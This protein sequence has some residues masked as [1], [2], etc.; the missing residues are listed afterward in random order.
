MNVDAQ[1]M[2]ERQGACLLAHSE[3]CW[4]W[5]FRNG[6]GDGTMT[7]YQVFPGVMLSFN[8]FHME[9]YDCSFVSQG[10]MLAIDHCREGRMEY[11]VGDNLVGYTASGDMKLD[12]RRQ[13]AGVFSFPSCHYH[14]LTVGFDLDIAARSL[15][16]QVRDFPVTPEKLLERWVLADTPRVVHG[17]QGT[18]HIFGELY[19]VPEKIRMPYFRLKILELLLCLDAMT[20]PAD[21]A[22]QP[23]FYKS[24]VEKVK[25]I[26]QFLMEHVAESFTQEELSARFDIPMTAMKACFRSVYGAAIGAWLLRYRMSLAAELLLS[27]RE[28][29]VAEVGGRVGYD[30]PGKF[31][32][33]FKR[34]MHLTPSQYRKERGMQHEI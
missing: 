20:I 10:R 5:Q 9:R 25:A 33:A 11:A 12:L 26:R 16:Q 29:S 24:Q 19:R 13:H 15:A 32:E 21:S 4:V 22:G 14:G 1:Q 23:Y 7:V 8:D 34:V 6:T 30:N 28:L 18:E 31:T 3:D 2:F 17:A 27:R